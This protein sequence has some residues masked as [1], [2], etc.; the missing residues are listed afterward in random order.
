MGPHWGHCEVSQ[1][2]AKMTSFLKQAPLKNRNLIYISV[3]FPSFHFDLLWGDDVKQFFFKKVSFLF[4]PSFETNGLICMHIIWLES[5]YFW[6]PEVNFKQSW[7]SCEVMKALFAKWT[8]FLK[9]APLKTHNLIYISV[10]FQSFHFGPSAVIR[11]HGGN[12]KVMMRSK[13]FFFKIWHHFWPDHHL[14]HMVWYTY[15]YG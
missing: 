13:N 7:R 4:L 12:D 14:K 11:G 8:P 5:Y 2:C 9:S 10:Y 15:Q 3:Y 6:P 1:L